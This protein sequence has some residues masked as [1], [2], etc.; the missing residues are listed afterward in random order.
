M[1]TNNTTR[2]YTKDVMID[3]ET[4]STKSNAAIVSIGAIKFNRHGDLPLL[5]AMNQF[6]VRVSRESCE[7]CG[8]HV[9]PQ[10][11]EWWNNQDAEIRYEAL[12]NPN[13]R[14]T[15]KDALMK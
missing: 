8:M 9:D 4:L 3:I 6:Y 13:D 10:T 1:S 5:D 2:I 12:E 7:T 14:L 11:I 15:I